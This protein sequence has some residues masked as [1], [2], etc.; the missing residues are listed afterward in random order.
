[1]A[2]G[3]GKV[4]EF[5]GVTICAT[6]S[7]VEGLAMSAVHSNVMTMDSSATLSCFSNPA[8]FES[9]KPVMEYVRNANNQS[10]PRVRDISTVIAQWQ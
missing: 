9:L 1:M 10:I 6:S 3:A 7:S 4:E 5:A 8:C 2:S